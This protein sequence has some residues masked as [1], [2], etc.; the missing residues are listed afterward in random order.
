[1]AY[2]RDQYI[3]QIGPQSTEE[4][5]NTLCHSRQSLSELLVVSSC[6]SLTENISVIVDRFLKPHIPSIPSYI[7]DTNH[8]LE[9][10]RNL[11]D[12][13]VGALLVTLDVTALYPSI[14]HED[15]LSALALFL[16]DRN[17]N[18]SVSQDI[19]SLARLLLTRNFSDFN[20]VLYLQKS[21][22]AIGTVMAVCYATVL[23]NQFETMAMA[24]FTLQPSVWWRY[25]DDVF[26]VWT[27]GGESLLLFVDHLISVNRN[28]KFTVAA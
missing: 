19:A 25:I 23:M 3:R 8:F 18:P 16:A 17:F 7:K 2:N 1:M 9:R 6:G 12:L 20:N 10:L 24:S 11:G 27:H 14:P 22:T 21:V 4:G 13:P 5:P 26:C 15:G 28:I